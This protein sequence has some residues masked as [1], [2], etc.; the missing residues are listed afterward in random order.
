MDEFALV[1]HALATDVLV[2]VVLGPGLLGFLQLA[3]DAVAAQVGQDAAEPVIKHAGLELKAHP[4][5]DG[6][7]INASQ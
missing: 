4:E 6:L 1:V 7:F 5:A 2:T 3:S